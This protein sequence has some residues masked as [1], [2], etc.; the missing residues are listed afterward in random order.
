MDELHSINVGPAGTFQKSGQFHSEPES[1]DAIIAHIEQQNLDHVG[2]YFH[3]GLV[4]EAAGMAGAK[5]FQDV[6]AG[7][8]VHG[9][10][11][12]W[13]TGWWETIQK[14]LTDIFSTDL[15]RSLV[16]KVVE[17]V[18]GHFTGLGAKGPGGAEVEP[19]S[20]LID[21]TIDAT[22][23]DETRVRAK[24]LSAENLDQW[25]TE[26]EAELEAE[27]EIDEAFKDLY[28][29]PA[30]R[31]SLF[32]DPSQPADAD[33]KS[34]QE[35][36]VL[37]W[38]T[39]AAKIARIAWRVGSRFWG[40][41]DHGLHATV[42]EEVLREFYVADLVK[43]LEWDNMKQAARDMWLP[44]TGLSDLQQHA[45]TYLLEQL[46]ALKQ[47]RPNLTV[48][49]VA[50]SAGAI[51]VC[52]LFAALR[53]RYPGQLRIRNVVFLAPA[54]TSHLFYSHMIKDQ[55]Q[56]GDFHMFTMPDDL[57]R[58][59]A[60][61]R[62]FHNSL[63]VVYP[64]SLLYIV[65]GILEE[66]V[67]SPLVGMMRFGSGKAP[68]DSQMLQKI[69]EYLEDKSKQRLTLSTATAATTPNPPSSLATS[70]GA[71]SSDKPTLDSIQ[72]IIQRSNQTAP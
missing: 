35:K 46:I 65:S 26:L 63:A 58:R 54:A 37:S 39:V 64:S 56:F 28:V 6:F 18:V 30:E 34:P 47:K 40:G 59:D 55:T 45:G 68:F 53:K 62:P 21:P 60:V 24:Q 36:A 52:E 7:A 1:V 14:N 15:F 31:T 12:V 27:I 13:E 20:L 42:A 2:I 44:N 17:K 10:S 69:R 3:G 48:D 23:A 25:R 32:D 33:A 43:S 8:N 70:H 9:I 67:D 72:W 4:D 19:E 22:F 57:E 16:E 66:E 51:V 38:L 5:R 49:L 11:L 61:M 50:H 29:D 41:R 71:F